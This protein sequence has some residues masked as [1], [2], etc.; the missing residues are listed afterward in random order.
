MNLFAAF[1]IVLMYVVSGVA[2]LFSPFTCDKNVLASLLD[3]PP[4]D[5]VVVGLLVLAGLWELTGSIAILVSYASDT[6]DSTTRSQQRKVGAALL[7]GFTVLVTL[8][9]KTKPVYRNIRN[10]NYAKVKMKLIPVLAN[11]TATGALL[12]VYSDDTGLPR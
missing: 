11:I 12:A 2:K 3:R 7:I 6:V 5:S 10:K 9:F 1:A 8:L 4:C